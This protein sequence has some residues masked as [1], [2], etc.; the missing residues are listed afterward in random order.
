LNRAQQFAEFS[1]VPSVTRLPDQI[2]TRMP[3]R[4]DQGRRFLMAPAKNIAV[5]AS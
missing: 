3:D 4:N 5:F 1:L 2:H